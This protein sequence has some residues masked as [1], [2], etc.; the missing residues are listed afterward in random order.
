M[1]LNVNCVWLFVT[2]QVAN[3]QWQFHVP[4]AQIESMRDGGEAGR[5]RLQ[6]ERERVRVWEAFKMLL[7]HFNGTHSA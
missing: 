4:P 7:M 6:G 5:E 1:K 2:L 3:T